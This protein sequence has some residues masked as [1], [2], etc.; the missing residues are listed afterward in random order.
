MIFK[1][2]VSNM[3]RVIKGNKQQTGDQSDQVNIRYHVSSVTGKF[4]SFQ[5]VLVSTSI[6]TSC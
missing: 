3:V 2:H 5:S 6:L 4:T 1:C